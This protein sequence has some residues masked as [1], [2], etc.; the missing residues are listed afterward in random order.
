M[1]MDTE[2]RY[3]KPATH[4]ILGVVRIGH[5]ERE[6]AIFKPTPPIA[7]YRSEPMSKDAVEQA[8]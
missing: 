6:V 2:T 1:S 7:L 3:Y 8:K 4:C 5:I